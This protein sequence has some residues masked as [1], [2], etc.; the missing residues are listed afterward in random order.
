MSILTFGQ[1]VSE[2]FPTRTREPGVALGVASQWL[3]N[4]V[5]SLTTPY[6]IKNLGWATFLLWGLF[7]AGIAMYSWWGLVETKN[8]SLEE[9][10]HSGQE[11]DQ[12][13]GRGR[14][15]KR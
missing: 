3:F 11:A 6:M 8:K 13:D 15:R 10:A 7:D 4:F 2:I 14:G 9:I 1:Y 5:F 12:R